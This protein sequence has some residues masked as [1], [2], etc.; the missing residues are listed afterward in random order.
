LKIAIN[1]ILNANGREEQR[2]IMPNAAAP[3]ALTSIEL[4]IQQITEVPPIMK[5]Q[6]LTAKKEINQDKI[7]ASMPDM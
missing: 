5:A 4:P 6:D 2:V 1:G 7:H 3:P